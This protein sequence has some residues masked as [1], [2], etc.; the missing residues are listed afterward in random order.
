[1]NLKLVLKILF[2]FGLITFL[3]INLNFEKIAIIKTDAVWPFFT[4]VFITIVSLAFMTVRW[5]V[6]IRQFENERMVLFDLFR[7]YLMGMF[8]NI[9]FP[10][11]IGG[12]VIRTQRLSKHKGIKVKDA[13]LITVAER[14]SG[15]Y[16]LL[17]LLS[18]SFLFMNFPDGLKVNNILPVWVFRISPLLV[19]ICISLVKVI[20]NKYG[21]FTSY[22]F[23][24]KIVVISLLAQMG[25]VTIAYVFSQYFG[26][27]VSFSAFLFIMPLVF[28]ATVL[29]ISLGGLGVREGAFSGL[30]ILY[31]VDSS[32]AIIISLLM[33]LV[34]VGVGIIG[35]FVYLK[36]A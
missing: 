3:I 11:A 29:P 36:E 19:L 16:G 9:F 31:G 20:L 33:Y 7:Y 2:S 28:I 5:Q 24:S 1:M 17:I 12:D 32:I 22:A 27:A 21:L 30:M 10:G 35:Y 26:L 8:F 34:K 13:T 23:I 25:D 6:L 14:L 18:F 4:G 15:V